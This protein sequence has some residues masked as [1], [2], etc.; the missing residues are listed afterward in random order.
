MLEELAYKCLCDDK[1]HF[2][3]PLSNLSA[4]LGLVKQSQSHLK[5]KSYTIYTFTHKS[6]VEYLAA[7]YIVKQTSPQLKTLLSKI[8]EVHDM[9]RLSASLIL[10]FVCG[11]FTDEDQQVPVCEMFIPEVTSAEYDS[12]SQHLGLQCAAELHITELLAHVMRKCVC[13][14]VWCGNQCNQYCALGI[15]RLY[16]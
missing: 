13:K 1:L 11:L 7:K 16:G 14:K 4:N 5:L 3:K 8:P 12:H 15:K 2:D 9:K 6:L 10:F